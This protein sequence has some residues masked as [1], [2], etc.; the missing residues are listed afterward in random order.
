MNKRLFALVVVAFLLTGFT[1]SSYS[2]MKEK[3]LLKEV[4]V[5][6]E[7]LVPAIQGEA[8]GSIRS[9]RQLPSDL[10]ITPNEPTTIIRR[11]PDILKPIS[12][13]VS[14]LEW[15]TDR[16]APGQEVFLTATG[17]GD[18]DKTLIYLSFYK[19]SQFLEELPAQFDK[20]TAQIAW[21][22][23]SSTVRKNP[24]TELN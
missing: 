13:I 1:V 8:V 11:T 23:P 16:A 20:T 19:E 24:F 6:D 3:T 9:D 4:Y 17:T 12:C 7:Q 10:V 14:S 22:V 15:N 18:C 2:Y 21:N 5:S